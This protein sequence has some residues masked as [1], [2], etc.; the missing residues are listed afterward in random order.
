MNYR[1]LTDQPEFTNSVVRF[2]DG[3]PVSVPTHNG[4]P[5]H[6]FGDPRALDMY[7]IPEDEASVGEARFFHDLADKRAPTPI[8]HNAWRA[9]QDIGDRV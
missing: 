1:Q 4:M 5:T 6:R 7:V 8:S 2:I 9:M 3:I